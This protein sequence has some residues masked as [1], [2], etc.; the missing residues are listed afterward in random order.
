MLQGYSRITHVGFWRNNVRNAPSNSGR[1]L[2]GAASASSGHAGSSPLPLLSQ[3]AASCLSKHVKLFL[4]FCKAG[5]HSAQI[6]P[7][8][9]NR[10]LTS[11]VCY[12]KETIKPD[13][14]LLPISVK[15]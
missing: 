10:S 1:R 6:T 12:H 4:S 7:M 9:G 5:S 11:V 13:Q 2:T 8:N 3:R 15:N 14:H